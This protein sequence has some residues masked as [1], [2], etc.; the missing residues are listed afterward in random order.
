MQ[1]TQFD[2]HEKQIENLTV[3]TVRMTGS[4]RDCG[5]GFGKIGRKFGSRICGKAMMLCHDSEYR[6]KDANFEVAMPIKSGKPT[7][8]IEVKVLPGGRF[9][10]LMH[11]GPYSEISRSYEKILRFAKEQ[12]LAHGVPSREVYHKGPGIIFRGNPRKYLTEIQ[13][14]L[15]DQEPA[16]A[17]RS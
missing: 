8:E 2:V 14:K 15:V 13:L 10:S 7:N 16:D 1:T 4:Y 5:K 3:A 12:G 17:S 9:L 11:L 6:D